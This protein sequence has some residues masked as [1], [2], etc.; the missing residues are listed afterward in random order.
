M[1]PGILYARKPIHQ[2]KRPSTDLDARNLRYNL[3]NTL[4]LC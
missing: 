3:A 2:P 4:V 1:I